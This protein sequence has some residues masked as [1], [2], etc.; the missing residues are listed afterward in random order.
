MSHDPTELVLHR[1]LRAPLARVWEVLSDADHLARW[2]GPTGFRIETD[3]YQLVPGGVWRFLMVGPDGRVYPNNVV[4]DVVVPQERLVMRYVQDDP[5]APPHHITTLSLTAL[6]PARTRITLVVRFAT[7][8]ACRAAVEQVGAV[9]GGRQ[10][11]AR[12][13]GLVEAEESA[14]HPGFVMRRVLRASPAVVWAAWTD[15]AH[16]TRWFHPTVWSIFSASLDLRVGGQFVYGFRGAHLPD[17]WAVWRFTEV[18]APR[19]L[20]FRLAFAD[21]AGQ[22]VASPFGGP[23]PLWQ[24]TVVTIEPHAGIG[25]GAVLTIQAAPWEGSPEEWAAFVAAIPSMEGGWGETLDSLAA[26]VETAI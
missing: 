11:L 18:D 25:R 1:D 24:D 10:T 16:L 2:W 13:A 22:P 20:A 3:V 17:T 5:T 7:E 26:F 6:D 23:W 8:A 12:L 15:A 9:E 14:V 19:R 4:F 21:A